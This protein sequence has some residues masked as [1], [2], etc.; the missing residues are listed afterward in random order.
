MDSIHKKMQSALMLILCVAV[1]AAA[2]VADAPVE[3]LMTSTREPQALVL[4]T[5]PP[6]ATAAQAAL[7][8]GKLDMNTADAWMLTAIPG[9]GEKIAARVITYREEHGGFVDVRELER[10]EGIGSKLR[11]V[12]EQYVEVK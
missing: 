10:I 8:R 3:R 7:A 11:E 5:V 2:N 4:P 9:V 1:V 6:A 12:M